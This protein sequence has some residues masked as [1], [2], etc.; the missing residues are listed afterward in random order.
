MREEIQHSSHS[1]QVVPRW[2]QGGPKVVSGITELR[3][4]P[5]QENRD[6]GSPQAPLPWPVQREI[7]L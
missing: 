3:A 7:T 1:P 6:L 2:S 5:R 4:M